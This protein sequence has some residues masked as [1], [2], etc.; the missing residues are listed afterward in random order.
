MSLIRNI[1]RHEK[2]K[3]IFGFGGPKKPRSDGKQRNPRHS[4]LKW[5][6]TLSLCVSFVKLLILV[7]GWAF[8]AGKVP[9]LLNYPSHDFHVHFRGVLGVEI[10]YIVLAALQSWNFLVVWH[11][12]N[13][14]K[15]RSMLVAA[16]DVLLIALAAADVGLVE[17]M[18]AAA[19]STADVQATFPNMAVDD[20]RL[21]YFEK[22]GID[23]HRS[24]GGS[25][26]LACIDAAIHASAIAFWHWLL[27]PVWRFPDNF[28]PVIREKRNKRAPEMLVGGSDSSPPSSVELTEQQ[29]PGEASNGQTSL[30]AHYR[31]Q[32]RRRAAAGHSQVQVRTQVC[33]LMG[34]HGLIYQILGLREWSSRAPY[35]TRA[36]QWDQ[37]RPGS[38]I[39]SSGPILGVRHCNIQLC[40]A[41][42]E[43]AG[44]H[45]LHH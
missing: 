34:P 2:T 27:P 10:A 6:L 44:F 45:H 15:R 20:D 38:S 24:S 33:R 26:A 16:A 40:H 5:C 31:D 22:L 7:V 1:Y 11:R 18:L 3:Y 9:M 23:F 21:V 39:R 29:H 32:E 35:L 42:V 14:G 12:R 13:H 30:A 17:S 8:R 36:V 41:S 4:V 43:S 25:L 28:E 37:Q 19:P